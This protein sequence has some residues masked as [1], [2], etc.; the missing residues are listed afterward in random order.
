MPT[1]A[2]DNGS[3]RFSGAGSGVTRVGTSGDAM[4]TV[5][6]HPLGAAG[7][8]LVPATGLRGPEHGNVLRLHGLGGCPLMGLLISIRHGPIFRCCRACKP[9]TA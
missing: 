6:E 9:N 3:V 5:T 4:G 7:G 2:D 1:S 8:G